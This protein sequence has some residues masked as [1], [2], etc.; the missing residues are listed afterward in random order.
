MFNNKL[1]TKKKAK[2]QFKN[3]KDKIKVDILSSLFEQS[4]A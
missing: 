2:N 1:V 3:K 4:I